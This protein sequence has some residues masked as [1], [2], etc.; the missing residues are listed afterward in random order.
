MTSIALTVHKDS[1]VTETTEDVP[2]VMGYVTF[3]A[4]LRNKK[5]RF[6][7]G[8]RPCCLSLSVT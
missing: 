6:M 8:T 4:F 7:W 2:E 1:P 5:D 3:E